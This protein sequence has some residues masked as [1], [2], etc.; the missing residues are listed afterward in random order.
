MLLLV[1]AEVAVQ[2]TIPQVG[3]HDFR[4]VNFGALMTVR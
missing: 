3:T 4:P 2:A 1:H